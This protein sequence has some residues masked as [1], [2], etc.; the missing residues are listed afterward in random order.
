MINFDKFLFWSHGT[1]SLA[2]YFVI[3]S[4]V[5]LYQYE[6][7]KRNDVDL[8]HLNRDQFYVSGYF[9]P[10]RDPK[11]HSCVWLNWANPNCNWMPSLF[12]TNY[13][14]GPDECT[15]GVQS[16]HLWRY[17][18]SLPIIYFLLTIISIHQL[19]VR[20]VNMKLSQQYPMCAVKIS[21][22]CDTFVQH[23]TRWRRMS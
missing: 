8:S 7:W 21:S 16:T 22:T 10:W 19:N 4:I 6:N 18:V 14:L 3:A 12:T 5:G 23:L 2:V 9:E 13:H 17:R 20:D 11:V 15:F 1:T